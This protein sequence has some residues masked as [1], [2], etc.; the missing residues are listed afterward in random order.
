MNLKKRAERVIVW[1]NMTLSM[2]VNF[3]QR[4]IN[5]ILV[6]FQHIQRGTVEEVLV[7]LREERT[8]TLGTTN[9]VTTLTIDNI[10]RKVKQL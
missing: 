2:E 9:G 4:C 10:I 7:L 5:T 3:R 1:M 8:K 6:N